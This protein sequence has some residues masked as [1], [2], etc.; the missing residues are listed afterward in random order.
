[1]EIDAT[2][3]RAD[4]CLE[5]DVCLVGAGPAGL[6][7]AGELAERGLRVALLESGGRRRERR[8]Q[9]L[10]RAEVVGGPYGDLRAMRHR[11]LGG[12]ARLWNTTVRGR[13]GA[14]YAPLDPIDF[15]PRAAPVLPGWPIAYAE[16]EPWYRGAQT[17]CGLGPFDYGAARW[18]DPIAT[19]LR[20]DDDVLES[21]VYQLGAA[22]VFLDRAVERAAQAHE[23]QLVTH[24]TASLLVPAARGD[25]LEE[26]HARR[27]DGARIRVRAAHF[28]LA[29]GAIE[30]ARLV[31]ASAAASP[32]TPFD[33]HGLVGSGFMEHPRDYSLRLA[34]G[35]AS[36]LRALAFYDAREA[37]D[38]TLVA[39]R[40]A[41]REDVLRRHALPN[42][43]VTLLPSLEPPR[44]RL[45]GWFPR[46]RARPAAARGYPSAADGWSTRGVAARAFG[47][48]R[49]L[50]NLE[51]RPYRENRVVLGSGRDACGLPRAELHWCW[52][53]E[54][55]AQLEQLQTLVG[56]ALEASG[57]GRVLR[58]PGVAPDPCAHH[59]AGTTRMSAD[60]RDGVVDADGRF[61]ALENLWAAG[62]SV[63]PAAGFA[64]PVL[65][66]VALALR[67]AQQLAA[68]L[69]RDPA[70]RAAH[71]V[72][73]ARV[74]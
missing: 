55:Q 53:P 8:L 22:D 60:P 5:A 11:Q 39:G 9:E 59:H 27:P 34:S 71:A 62:A 18:S 2:T 25:R 6:V 65:T 23:V 21:R 64:N 24:A 10:N 16:L 17:V 20:V 28:V 30:N 41:L 70:A 33:P 74:G 72:G 7:V 1:V 35:D 32:A 31:L 3:L 45:L 48:F 61:H 68:R 47:G 73:A 4:A 13:P 26:V 66:V 69:A 36:L 15:E 43:S 44:S 40:L 56:G 42:A 51:Q 38:G 63:F 12:T 29:T 46:I 19:P 57:L 14:K 50:V 67:V 52:R 37:S 54:E 49:L 58:A